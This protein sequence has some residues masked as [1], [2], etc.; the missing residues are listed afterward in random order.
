MQQFV[1]VTGFINRMALGM[2]RKCPSLGLN[3]VHINVIEIAAELDRSVTRWVRELG[4]G[5]EAAARR[6]W[7]YARARLLATAKRGGNAPRSYDEEDVAQSV[8][9]NLCLVARRGDFPDIA[10]RDELWRLLTAMV[11]NK[12]RRKA[13]DENRHKRGG[14]VRHV[15]I[16]DTLCDEISDPDGDPQVATIAQD[17]CARLLRLLD[18]EEVQLV[19]LL[20]VE[21]YTNSEIAD[22]IGCTRRS[23][24]RRLNLIRDAWARELTRVVE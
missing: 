22:Q 16:T 20:K 19:A 7:R 21:G 8:F 12:A 23:V 4:R 18:R 6:L 11:L 5:D 15:P 9:G 2:L 24:Q 3:D 13:R 1:V 14:G 10:D 17:E